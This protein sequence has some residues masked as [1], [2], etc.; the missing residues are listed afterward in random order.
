M[1]IIEYNEKYYLDLATMISLFR[2]TL[3]R[4]KNIESK[5]NIED[6]K[7]ELEEYITYKKKYKIYL[8]IE[9]DKALGYIILRIDGVIWVEQIYVLE[10]S[11]R[12]GVASLLY[13]FSE[14]VSKAM[15]EDTLYNY[16]HPNNNAIINF[17]KSKDYTVINLIEIRKKYNGEET[18]SKIKIMDNEFD[19]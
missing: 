17:L 2:V 11:R 8:C 5:P 14:N 19:Y 7:E 18:L 10:E 6:A 12:K 15:G 13:D 3:R 4:F 16:V 9:D 1:E